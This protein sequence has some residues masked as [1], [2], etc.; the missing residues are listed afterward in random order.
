MTT[1]TVRAKYRVTSIEDYGGSKKIKMNAVYEPDADRTDENARFTKATPWGELAMT[2]DNP[3][4][5]DQ[6]APNQQWYLDF[7]RADG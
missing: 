4:A 1:H 6:F 5:A 2:V 3:A 7:A